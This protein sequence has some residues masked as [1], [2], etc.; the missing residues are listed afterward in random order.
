MRLKLITEIENE[1]QKILIIDRK[2][3]DLGQLLNKELSK[4]DSDIYYVSHESKEIIDVSYIFLINETPKREFIEKNKNRKIIYIYVGVKKTSDNLAHWIYKNQV[5]HVKVINISGAPTEDN[6]EKI[7]WFSFSK[8]REVYLNLQ[9][10]ENKKTKTAQKFSLSSF[11]TL[12]KI[13]ILLAIF[14]AIYYLLIFPFIAVSSILIYKSL[15][16]LKK[17]KIDASRKLLSYAQISNSI[18]KNIYTVSR[19][20]YLFLSL[21]L[22]PDDLIA[23]NERAVSALD[24]SMKIY[25]H[26]DQTMRLIFKKTKSRDEKKEVIIRFGEI[27]TGVK[28]LEGDVTILREKIPNSP[29]LSSS[30]EFIKK[31]KKLL[32]Y[33]PEIFAEG[34]EQKYLLLFAN[35]MEIRPGGGFIGSYGVLVMKDLTLD[36]IE[37]YDVYDADGRLTEHIEPPAAIRKYLNQPNWFLRDSAFSSDFYE[38]YTQAKLFLE[39][40]MNLF[41]FAGGAMITTTAIQNS[42]SAFDDIYLPD[43]GE[44]VNQENF[45]LK[46]QTHSEQNFFP[47]SI[48]KKS[49]LGSLARQMIINMDSASLVKLIE[50][51]KTS[52]DEKQAVLAFENSNIQNVMDSLYWSGKNILP[53]CTTSSSCLNDFIFPY[54]ANLGVNKAN[55]Y[56]TRTLNQQ[57]RIDSNGKV[58]NSF[59]INLRNDS[60]SSIFPGG[61]YKNYFQILLSKN[62]TIKAITKNGVLIEDFEEKQ[63]IYKSLGFFVEVPAQ[64]TVEIKLDYQLE[65]RLERGKQIYQLIFQKQ[66][67]SKNSDLNLEIVLPSNIH[68]V[69]QNFR[70]LVK[71]NRILYN[72][73]LSQ[74]KIFIIELAREQ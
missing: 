8:S 24:E 56:V 55:F 72:T 66:I 41:G 18:S 68:L 67:G 48:Q 23:V 25:V 47:G 15:N 31:V 38:N 5:K 9:F 30:I 69:N 40:E 70:P 27:A 35:N 71:D 44:T 39:K 42:L 63:D 21:A 54:D 20:G 45:Y 22:W 34:T 26:A 6:L 49:F 53:K 29:E 13:W 1:R 7:L 12:R 16:E 57:I 14:I 65:P 37:V 10:I 61:P 19:P 59:V 74:D 52:L 62:S 17:E 64:N 11:L 3:S 58:H 46:A 4:Y 51:F 36:K 73:S 28:K 32:P 33:F 2:Q 50:G 60:P 43:Q